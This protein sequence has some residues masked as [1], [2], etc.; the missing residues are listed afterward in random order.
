MSDFFEIDP[1]YG[2]R[3]DWTW[4][5]NDQKY[6]VKRMQDA[7]PAMDRAKEMSNEGGLN[8]KDIMQGWWHY[9]TIPPGVQLELMAKGISVTKPEDRELLLAEINTNYPNLKCTTGNLGGK[10]KKIYL[11]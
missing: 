3:S 2:I 9:C 7:E 5:E 4:S 8:R 11:G 1:D 6:T 10:T